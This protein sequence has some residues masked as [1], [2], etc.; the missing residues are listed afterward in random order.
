MNAGDYK[1]HHGALYKT[2]NA[3]YILWTI[4]NHYYVMLKTDPSRLRQQHILN[5]NIL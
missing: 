2:F 5:K 1:A 3:F 4:S